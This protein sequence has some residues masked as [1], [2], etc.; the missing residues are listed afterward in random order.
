MDQHAGHL[1][2]FYLTKILS[3]ILDVS[4]CLLE[5]FSEKEMLLSSIF[6]DRI[7]NA[8]IRWLRSVHL[9]DFPFVEALKV[10][11]FSVLLSG[12]SFLNGNYY[13]IFLLYFYSIITFLFYYSIIS[14]F[15]WRQRLSFKSICNKALIPGWSIISICCLQKDLFVSG[16][17]VV[18]SPV[19]S[20][21]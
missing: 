4:H 17:S 12:F 13:Y 11:W 7:P 5:K 2:Y 10:V 3:V 1:F 19:Y 18:F 14:I 6:S 16:H 8:D 20:L 15:P 21:T 9:F